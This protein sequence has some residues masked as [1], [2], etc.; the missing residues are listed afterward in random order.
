MST[1]P[2][3]GERCPRHRPQN[4]HHHPMT[5]KLAAPGHDFHGVFRDD[6]AARA[7]YAES[8]GIGRV[9]P[10]GV[11]V[12]ASADDV[13]A[14]VRWARD[15]NLALVPRASGSSMPG[16]AIGRG[17]VVDLSR[18]DAIGDPD[19]AARRI[20]VGPGAIRNRVDARARAVG[21]RFPVDPSS[22]AFCTVG[23]M[24]ST[25]AA[26]ARTLRFGAMRRWV[27][28]LD[29]VFADGSRAVVRRGDAAPRVGAVDRFL[30]GVA[31]EI[32]AAGASAGTPQ[33]RKNSSGYALA[34]YA[35]SQELVDLLV[36][37]EGTLCLF[38]GMELDLTT[39]P[40]ATASLLAGY[41][42]LDDAVIGAGEAQRGGASACE[43]LDKT[44]LDVAARGSPLPVPAE[45]E[46]VL[47][48]ELEASS[49]SDAAMSARRLAAE[50]ERGGATHITIGLD[51][52]AEERLWELRHAASP[53]L[54]RLDPSLKSMQFIEDGVVPPARLADYVRGVRA[55]LAAHDTPGVIFGHAGD[56]HVHVNPLVDV[57]REGWRDR[58]AGILSDVVN[59]TAKLDGSLSGEHGDGALRA[60][61]LNRTTSATTLELARRVKQAFDPDGLLN[62]GVKVPL[63]DQRP[64]DDIK[65]DP[66]LPAPPAAAARVLERVERERAYA[67]FRLAM[68]EREERAQ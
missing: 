64:I 13:V 28:A 36:G 10:Q 9:M 8:A 31:P 15:G 2:L 22:G 62:P 35:D 55:A 40:G 32:R 42:S 21:L 24:A 27:H 34:D 49:A 37:S 57:R 63:R 12:P 29:C 51:H 25:N 5:G 58:V 7:V 46:A 50:L 59:L 33:L 68:L 17:V 26:G 3:V 48:I 38:V 41:A 11:A 66:T 30:A 56:A 23:G 65:Y 16:G 43:L 53:I 47:L 14:L 20:A 18:L 52:D 6:V 60:P 54:S 4:V 39:L 61:L 45:T 19:V 1:T 67:E 44:F